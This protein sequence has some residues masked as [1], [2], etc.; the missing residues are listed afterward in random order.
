MN[1]RKSN[2]FIKLF[3]IELDIT[4]GASYTE[5]INNYIFYFF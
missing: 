1:N 5:N 3:N 4:Y 2:I